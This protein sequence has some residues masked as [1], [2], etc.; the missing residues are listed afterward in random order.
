[1]ARAPRAA[2]PP[3]APSGSGGITRVYNLRY[4]IAS[5]VSVFLALAVGLVLG[6]VVVERCMLDAQKTTLVGSLTKDFQSIS[7]ENKTMR[8]EVEAV[9]GF[10]DATVAYMVDGKL[11]GRTVVLLTTPARSDALAA[12]QGAVKAAGGV[13]AVVTLREEHAGLEDAAT[14]ERA[15][16]LTRSRDVTDTGELESRIASAL[17]AEWTGEGDRPAT[18]MLKSVGAMSVEGLPAGVA[19]AGVV[20]VASSEATVEP[21]ALEIAIAAAARGVPAVGVEVTG[22]ETRAADAASEAGLAAVDHADLPDGLL[23]LVWTLAE[24]AKGHYGLDK[25]ATARFPEL[26]R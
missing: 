24:G 15:R 8:T 6:T 3:S 12:A 25:G 14:A 20:L 5:L 1:D 16:S 10:S 2:R 4:H 26:R 23:S 18:E 13:A 17:A 11:R 7:A 9:R 22:Q 21:V 19:V